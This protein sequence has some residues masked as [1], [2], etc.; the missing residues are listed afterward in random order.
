[1]GVHAVEPFFRIQ[2]FECIRKHVF[3]VSGVL[4]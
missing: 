4:G 3:S 1:L 2:V